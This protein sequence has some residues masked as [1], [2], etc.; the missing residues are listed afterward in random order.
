MNHWVLASFN[1]SKVSEISALL[2]EGFSLSLLGSYPNAIEPEETG[3]TLEENAA[4]KANYAARLTGLPAIA[5]DTGLCVEALGGD[6][7][8]FSARY[9]GV[10]SNSQANIEKLLRALDGQSNRKAYFETV[11]CLSGFPDGPVFLSGRLE[12]TIGHKAIG[13]GG[14]GY[15]PIFIPRGD[16]RTLAEYSK[17]EKNKISHRGQAISAF[18][19][20][21][22]NYDR[23]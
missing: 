14:F 6:P 7:G 20:W 16:T 19:D 23:K 9:A 4:L 22:K 8:V 5:D 15:D 1:P 11:I 13:Q 21:L 10:P 2:P 17:E 12:G 18:L 3:S